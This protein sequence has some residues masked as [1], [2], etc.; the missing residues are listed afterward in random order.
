MTRP[1]PTPDPDSGLL[2]LQAMLK[3]GH[4]LA[5]M[6]VFHERLGDVFQ[7]HLPGFRPVVM[8]GPEAARFVLVEARDWLKWRNPT[9]PVTGL[10]R[11]GVLVEDGETHDSLRQLMNPTLHSKMLA[12]YIAIMERRT[13]QIAGQW[14]EDRPINMLDGM[15][16]IT[17]LILIDALFAVD[18]TPELDSLFKA[19]IKS[20]QY[21]SPGLWMVW[22]SVPRKWRYQHHV[23]KLDRYLCRIIDDR[24]RGCGGCESGNDLLSIL[25]AAG[26]D[27]DTIRDQLLTMLIAGHD[28]STALLAWTIYLLGQHPNAA[29]KVQQEADQ[30]FNDGPL[31]TESLAR[32][33]YLGK[34]IKESLRLYPPIHLGSRVA[35]EDIPYGEYII[36]AGQRVIYSIYLTQR[37]PDHWDDPHSFDPDRY[38]RMQRIPPYTWLAF[39]G[40]PRNCIGAA[41]GQLEAKIIL[42]ILYHQF[43]VKLT[44]RR[45]HPRMGATLEPHPGVFVRLQKRQQRP[46]LKGGIHVQQ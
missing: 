42:A 8:A 28:T 31:T 2:A 45:I 30:L 27:D 4:P 17:L 1:I 43:D 11:R 16:R 35:A 32:A 38:D 6:Q 44:A 46:D 15:R 22:P 29:R 10:L 40:G 34:V 24:R 9:D 13:R 5:A 25:I 14:M 12:D 36:P 39:G 19:I 41:F 26:L 21:I 7:L 3:E 20:I 37:H 23:N 33:D 18:F